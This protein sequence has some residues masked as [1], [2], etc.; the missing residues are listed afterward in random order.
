[1]KKYNKPEAITELLYPPGRVPP[2]S[3]R[4]M[5]EHCDL[6][7]TVRR[8]RK[9]RIENTIVMRKCADKVYST[10]LNLWTSQPTSS[11]PQSEDCPDTQ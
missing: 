2:A 1:M 6:I 4:Y 3:L 5:V 9:V 11:Q 7:G 8:V 10:M